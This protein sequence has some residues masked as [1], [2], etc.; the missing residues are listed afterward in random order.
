MFVDLLA[1]LSRRRRTGALRSTFGRRSLAATL[2]P[3]LSVGGFAFAQAP[4]PAVVQIWLIGT[5]PQGVHTLGSEIEIGVFIDGPPVVVTGRPR[6]AIT[7]GA[8][9]RYAEFS[10]YRPGAGTGGEGLLRFLY[11]VQAS[12]RDDDGIS[13]PANALSLNG[14]SIEDADGNE[15]DLSHDAVPDNPDHRV[16]GSLNPAPTVTRVHLE[17]SLGDTYLLRD[18]YVEGEEVVAWVEFSQQVV[19]TGQPTLVLQIG[20]RARPA[21]LS[22]RGRDRLG[23]RYVVQ[24]S[25][26]DDDGISI[27]ANALSLNGGS[28]KGVGGNEADLSH[29][30]VPDDPE[31]KV[32][33]SIGAPPFVVGVPF[34]SSPLSGDT[35]GPG[36][37]IRALVLFNKP[38]AVTGNPRLVLRIGDRTRGADLYSAVGNQLRFRHFVE[39]SDRDDD[40]I[41][42]GAN[43]VLLN[44][45]SIR[46][47]RGN[48][49]DLTH[50]AV[51][52]DPQRKVDGSLSA[53]PTITRVAVGTRPRVGDAFG[54]GESILAGAWFSAPVEVTGS[55][56]FTIEVGMET[57]QAELH[58]RRGNLLYFEYVVQASDADA[59]GVSIP[60]D[61][62]VLDGGTI[63]DVNGNDAELAH[64]AVPDDATRKVNGASGPPTIS[65]VFF[66][67]SP[68]NQ[69]TYAAGESIFAL[70]TFTRG[71]R[72]TGEPAFALQVGAQ[73]RLAHHLPRLRAAAL[74]PMSSFHG[75]G[76][77]EHNV[78]FEYVVQPEDVDDDGIS[79]PA[80]ALT[81]NGGSIQGLNDGSDARLSHDAL[82][83]DPTRRVNGGLS[84][85]QAPVVRSL[86]MEPPARGVWGAGEAI[87]VALG[88][89]EGV[90]VAGSPQFALR[91]GAQTRFAEF[92]EQWGTSSLLFEYVVDES[93]VD[94]N[95]ISVAAD[96]V[97]LKGGTVRDNAGNDAALDLG[98][99]AFNDDPNYKVDGRMTAVPALP[100]GAVLALF[101][102]LL[103]GGWRHLTRRAERRP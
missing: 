55:P 85:E 67:R 7:V 48:D 102:A 75:A 46:D 97:D 32:D 28:I 11:V 45:G 3:F 17:R 39:A 82:A 88:F 63:T 100:A 19:G 84:D 66:S 74:L 49:A 41:S 99:R 77:D 96:A 10:S 16:N 93:D 51:R 64:D 43:A 87:T 58:L 26:R 78:Y 52:D 98:Y 38:V 30:A 24:A 83:D 25:D 62:F 47:S 9:T 12:D 53:A 13:I 20:D 14:G 22:G 57:R 54:V 70:A 91:I 44:G 42:I 76:E 2:L 73:T 103:C 101:F 94:S 59:D 35:F 6:V 21:V 72:V 90:T 61:A 34:G 29:D 18:T 37:E 15:A 27:P 95:G 60:A 68:A 89:T 50:E 33:G 71:V 31:H 86:T 81:L 92:Q 65:R 40:G 79:A 23:F 1:A 4:A 36:E 8:D 80:D 69:D 5:A 56:T